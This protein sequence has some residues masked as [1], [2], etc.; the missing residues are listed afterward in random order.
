MLL[1]WPVFW[2]QIVPITHLKYPMITRLQM[3]KLLTVSR[4]AIVSSSC[5]AKSAQMILM[6]MWYDKCR[7]VVTICMEHTFNVSVVWRNIRWQHFILATGMQIFISNGGRLT[8]KTPMI[9]RYFKTSSN[10]L[11]CFHCWETAKTYTGSLR[12]FSVDTQI[13]KRNCV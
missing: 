3:S 8:E 2:L 10:Y 4:L 13:Y 12:R 5:I 1:K 6:W 11:F 9:S 7:T